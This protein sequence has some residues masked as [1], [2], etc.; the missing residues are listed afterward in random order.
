MGITGIA[1]PGGGTPEKPV[2]TVHLCAVGPDGAV[3]RSVRL[4]GS[5]SAVRERSVV[6]AMQMLRELLLGGPPA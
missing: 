6:L 1:G 3:A 4:P 5:R 2:G